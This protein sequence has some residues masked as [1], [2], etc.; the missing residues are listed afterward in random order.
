MD[1]VNFNSVRLTTTL[2]NLSKVHKKGK[3]H[4]KKLSCVPGQYKNVYLFWTKVHTGSMYVYMYY[5]Y[6]GSVLLN[7]RRIL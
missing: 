2:S 7:I 6:V 3:T 1:T 4:F 5:M